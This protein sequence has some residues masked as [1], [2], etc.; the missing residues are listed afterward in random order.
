M[1]IDS[2]AR[3]PVRALRG[4]DLSAFPVWE[5]ALGEECSADAALLR[6]TAHAAVPLDADGQYIVA[7][8]ALI[9]QGQSYPACVEVRVDGGKARLT[10]MF[11]IVQ[12]RHLDFTGDETTRVLNQCTR[13]LNCYPVSWQ[14][15]VPLGAATVPAGRRVTRRYRVRLRQLWTRL[16]IATG[17]LKPADH[18]L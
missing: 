13:Q 12:N 5:W 9:S 17:N 15:A 18:A 4:A 7:A 2:T 8:N 14:R 6:P 1:P 16:R 10:P 3:L 11:L